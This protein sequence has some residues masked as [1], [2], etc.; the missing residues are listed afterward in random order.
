M[1]FSIWMENTLS[2]RSKELI[3]KAI[4]LMYR[5]WTARNSLV[6]EGKH[7]NAFMIWRETER[8]FRDWISLSN[9]KVTHPIAGNAPLTEGYV[10]CQVDATLFRE[11]K[12]V[13]FRAIILDGNS[14][15][16]AV[17]S[18][19]MDGNMDPYHA[20]AMAC[21]EALSWLKNMNFNKICLES[22][23]LNVVEAIPKHKRDFSYTVIIL[24]Q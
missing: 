7:I 14:N 4:F 9:K 10:F 19:P 13:G 3:N 16:L 17:T 6:W 23:C 2:T 12:S 18:G 20:E 15:F 1:D 24:D 21:W 22:D 11:T 8:N 5:I